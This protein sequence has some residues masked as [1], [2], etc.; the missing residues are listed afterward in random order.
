MRVFIDQEVEAT[1]DRAVK[2]ALVLMVFIAV[3]GLFLADG[4][5]PLQVNHTGWVSHVPKIV[6]A[7]VYPVAGGLA[8]TLTGSS[9][10]WV[11]WLGRTLVYFFV[12]FEG[13]A[14]VSAA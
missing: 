1:A 7:V 11:R 2:V 8:A 14:F 12:V 4:P 5:V 6:A 9:A 3:I 13:L 10:P